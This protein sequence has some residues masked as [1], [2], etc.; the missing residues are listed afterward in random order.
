VDFPTSLC[1]DF[2][3]TGAARRAHGGPD[4][5]PDFAALANWLDARPLPRWAKANP[6]SAQRLFARALALREAV[7]GVAF[8][9]ASGA[10]PKRQDLDTVA[11][12]AAVALRAL[13]LRGDGGAYRWTLEAANDP[14]SASLAAVALSCASLLTGEDLVRVR[15]CGNP[16][17]GWLFLDR[18]KNRSRKWC[19]MESCGNKMK[20]RRH[21]AKLKASKPS[22]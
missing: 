9:H 3:N 20:A 7:Y 10:K 19:E 16:T 4:G 18:S 21:Y 14:E 22:V 11:R 15:I 17:C 8:A 1:L 2:A 12:E 6:K 5:L 13:E